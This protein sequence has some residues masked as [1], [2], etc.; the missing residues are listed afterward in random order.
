MTNGRKCAVKPV[1][2]A[3]RFVERGVDPKDAHSLARMCTGI[4][5]AGQF[6]GLRRRDGTEHARPG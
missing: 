6:G 2:L 3:D 4:S 1:G 5:A